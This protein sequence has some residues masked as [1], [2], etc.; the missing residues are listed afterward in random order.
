MKKARLL[1]CLLS[2]VGLT[3]L[4]GAAPYKCDFSSA[5][6]TSDHAFRASSNWRHI[7]GSYTESG[8]EMF[9]KYYY[10]T[11]GGVNNSEYLEAANQFGSPEYGSTGGGTVY[12][13]LVTPMVKGDVKAY[14]KITAGYQSSA[15]I[16]VY[17]VEANGSVGPFLKK[18]TSADMGGS[19][20][21]WHQTSIAGGLEDY[22][23]LAL[24]CH[25]VSID[26]FEASDAVIT[27][28]PNIAF[29]S[30]IPSA[31]TGVLT[32]PQQ[33]NGKVKIT[34]MVTLTNTGEVDLEPGM[35]NY[36][37]TLFDNTNKTDLFTVPV[38]VSIAIGETSEEFEVSGEVES[39]IWPYSTSMLP[40]YLRENINGSV[41]KRA[42]SMYAEYGSKFIFRDK[43]STSSYNR[44]TALELGI[45]SEDVTTDFEIYNPGNAPLVVKGISVPEGY[46]ITPQGEFSVAA[47]TSADVTLTLHADMP[48]A[49]AGNLKVTYLKPFGDE[50]TSFTLPVSATVVSAN[51]FSWDFGTSANSYPQGSVAFSGIST[52]YSG[53]NYYLKGAGYNNGIILPLLH[54]EEGDIFSFDAARDSYSTS[55]EFSVKVYMS[56]NREEWGEPVYTLDKSQIT[57]MSFNNFSFASPVSGDYYVKFEVKNCR[58]DNLSGFTVVDRN[59]DIYISDITAQTPKQTGETLKFNVVTIAPLT[60]PASAYTV[61]LISGEEVI[62]TLTSKNLTGNAK[63]EISFPVEWT[64]NVEE[65][66]I[67]NLRARFTFTDGTV[68]E[69]FTPKA[70]TITCQPDFVFFNPTDT[71]NLY[72]KPTSRSKEITFGTT[73]E[74]GIPQEFDI[75]NWGSKNLEVTSIT[76][77]EGFSANLSS[78]TVTPKERKRL[79]I[80][81]SA[82]EPG[83]YSGKLII[84]YLDL[85][86]EEQT[87]Q[88]GIS[89]TLLDVNKW[90]AAFGD[91]S[92]TEVVWPD[93]TVHNSSM[94]SANTGTSNEP[95][96]AINAYSNGKMTSPKL[97][98]EEGDILE[99]TA[100][101]YNSSNSDGYVKIYTAPT[102]EALTDDAT[103]TLVASISGTSSDKDLLATSDWKTFSIAMPEAG[104]FYLG[105][106]FGN[107]LYVRSFYGLRPVSK[108][109]DLLIASTNIPATAMQNVAKTMSVSVHNFGMS[110][111]P[112]ETCTVAAFIDGCKVAETKLDTEIPVNHADNE[113]ALTIPVSVRYPEQG[114]FPVSLRLTYGNQ[115]ISTADV[116]V[117]FAAEVASANKQIGTRSSFNT[118]VP[119]DLYCYNSET[120]LLYTAEDLD[121]NDGDK[122]TDIMFKGFSSKEIKFK[123]DI[124]YEWTDD[125]EESKPGNGL[126]NADAK[127]MMTPVIVDEEDRTWADGQGSSDNPVELLRLHFDEPIVYQSG[128]SLRL[129]IAH[130][131]ELRQFT[132][133]CSFEVT[134]NTR[135]SYYHSNDTYNTFTS[136][137]WNAAPLPVMYLTLDATPTVVTGN[138]TDNGE[139][140]EGAVVKLVSRDGDNVQYSGSTA[141]DGTYCITVIQNGR[142]YDVT[143]SCN[144]KEDFVENCIFTEDAAL[145]FELLDV[146]EIN[147]AT[148]GHA[149][150]GSAIVKM[151]LDLE[152]GYNTIVLPFSLTAEETASIFGDDAIYYCGDYRIL[153]GGDLRLF[154]G[155]EREGITAGKPYLVNVLK[156]PEAIRFRGKEVIT[157]ITP[158]L[159][160]D[161]EFHGTY[162]AKAVEEGM[163][164]LTSGNFVEASRAQARNGETV[165]PYSGYV[166]VNNANVNMVTY[167][168]DEN[169]ASGIESISADNFT[170]DDVIFNLQGV[171]VYHPETGLY[172]VNGKKMMIK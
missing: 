57:G 61:Q 68:I 169:I 142:S 125:N 24:R 161:V 147:N 116:D 145:D 117:T 37:I 58:L 91:A 21:T 42:E 137:A 90:Y 96:W 18:L 12:D 133:G 112:A 102:R 148:G 20:E 74:I 143:A 93:G 162:E 160:E 105:F 106:D 56:Q 39:S 47:G 72:Y 64:P 165:A 118:K 1:A 163:H 100:K 46:T 53:N 128:K 156:N 113:A 89:G 22:Q 170:E 86:N 98:A 50:E 67:Y 8:E 9:M 30:V 62:S 104:D 141:A 95:I 108:D 130:V 63:T 139:S 41:V 49:Y 44:T 2:A 7:V 144:G 136:N 25:Y 164:L 138:V 29:E 6:D 132:S 99:I 48:G 4:L 3:G 103:R 69:S 166:K 34:F 159:F 94:S 127:A 168:I 77:P 75:F 114:T 10:H 31:T 59:Y 84:K 85:N 131:S 60:I 167:S 5:I 79:E 28:E 155:T 126:Y 149:A 14:T 110:S 43:G 150:S 101:L 71:Y 17:A 88:L 66:T 115:E 35:E 119:V 27:S 13:Y 87:Y 80:A 121:L 40:L 76:V 32:W 38:P 51:V 78:C 123:F 55:L 140:V 151:N 172:I 11:D 120:V 97:H 19:S 157:S 83:N 45:V 109:A 111:V 153:G 33:L 134:G 107:R 92:S 135:N 16:E 124:R 23:R 129:L 65:T 152:P 36:S 171:R 158:E 122:I 26:D 70:V 82:E 52:D 146:V 15:Y 81:M 73:N 154:F 54:A